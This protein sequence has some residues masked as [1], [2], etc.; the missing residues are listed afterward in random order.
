MI[1]KLHQ[2]DI[3]SVEN[4]KDPVLVVS[5]D[6]FNEPEKSLD[7]QYLSIAIRVRYIYRFKPIHWRD[8]FN[9]KI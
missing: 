8:M 5:K 7:V 9:V 6:L 3:L 1:E 4:I 2:G